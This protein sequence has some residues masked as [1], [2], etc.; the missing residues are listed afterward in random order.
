MA[1][2]VI[3]FSQPWNDVPLEQLAQKAGE[4]GYQGLELACSGDHFEVQRAQSNNDY[5][6]GRLDLLGRHELTLPV[7]STHRL[8]QAVGDA[9]GT[10]RGPFRSGGWNPGYERERAAWRAWSRVVTV[11]SSWRS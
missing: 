10:A 4:W 7:L 9:L 3:L 11:P 1:R 5:C 8:G 6:Q 2:T